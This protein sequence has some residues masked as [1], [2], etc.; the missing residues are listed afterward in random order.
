MTVGEDRLAKIDTNMCYGL[1]LGFVNSHCKCK[2]NEELMTG[3]SDG[4][5]EAGERRSQ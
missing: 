4:E 1:F 5:I 3:Q 2:L